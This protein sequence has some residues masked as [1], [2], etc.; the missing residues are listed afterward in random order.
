MPYLTVQEIETIAERIVR[1]YHRY[2]AQQNRK[3]TRIDPEIV[4]SNVLGLQIAYHKL[5]RFGHVLGLTCMLPVAIQVFDDV[6]HPVY[7]PL[8]GRTVFVDESLRSEN[9]NIGRHNFTLMH[10]ACHLV[11]GM[12]YPETYLGVQLRRVYYS[13]RFAPRNVTPDWEEWRTNMLA[14]AVLMPKDL[15]LQYMR[16][17]GLGKKMRMVNRIFAARQYEAF[18]QIADKMG[19]SKTASLQTSY[20]GII[21]IRLKGRSS[22]TS[23]QPAVQA[24]L[25]IF[26]CGI[27]IH[28]SSEKCNSFWSI[29]FR[30]GQHAHPKAG[31]QRFLPSPKLMDRALLTCDIAPASSEPI[32]SRRRRLSMVRI[33]SS[34]TMESLESPQLLQSSSMWVGSLFLSVWL[35]MAAAMTVGLY[36][37]PMSFCTIST[38]RTPPC[39]EPTTGLRSA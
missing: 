18:S 3:L 37:L 20:G 4:T 36:R 29:F 19:V 12:L 23:S 26:D 27:I 11:Y 14:S 5:S 9:A 15:I 32:F 35:V 7:A 10:E 1:A 31:C 16:E 39:S 17:Y 24:P 25:S 22:I 21:R 38:G 30:V 33:C 2:C 34:S 6:E 8:D 28:L 13:L